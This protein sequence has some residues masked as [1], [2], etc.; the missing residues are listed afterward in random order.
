M[1]FQGLDKEPRVLRL[2]LSF[3]LFSA[4]RELRVLFWK[5]YVNGRAIGQEQRS[6][7]S[8]CFHLVMAQLILQ[9]S[10]SHNRHPILIQA[11][12]TTCY[13]TYIWVEHFFL[14]TSGLN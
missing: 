12:N 14:P 5:F 8:G 9:G 11:H 3:F 10:Q 1:N 2:L 7:L 4:E 6:I 13:S